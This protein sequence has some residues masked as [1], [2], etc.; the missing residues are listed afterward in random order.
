MTLRPDSQ[1]CLL[2]LTKPEKPASSSWI[3]TYADVAA[4]AALGRATSQTTVSVATRAL[5]TIA[6][7]T[8]EFPL[9]DGSLNAP[10]NVALS[11]R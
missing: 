4:P 11:G 9:S 5:F 6:S 8:R 2:H 10:A 1:D 7:L 3:V